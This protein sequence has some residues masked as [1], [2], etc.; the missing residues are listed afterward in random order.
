MVFSVSSPEVPTEVVDRLRAVCL[1]LPDAFEEPAWVGTRWKVRAN[2]FAHVLTVERGWPE[3]YARAFGL[4]RTVEPVVVL[5]FRALGVDRDA[6]VG[7]GHPFYKPP[8]S[9]EVVG[10]VIT[11]DT[12]WEEVAELL[13][14]SFCAAAPKKLVE[15][16]E[17]PS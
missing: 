17:R 10:M 7:G 9:P 11:G 12:D 4:E 1:A 3:A 8:W 15:K 5:T 13:T 16:V 6:L 2:T 14:E